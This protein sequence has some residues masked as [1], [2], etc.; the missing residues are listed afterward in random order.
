MPL[1]SHAAEANVMLATP[2]L[3]REGAIRE[4]DMALVFVSGMVVI[5]AISEM[6]ISGTGTTSVPAITTR[7][8]RSQAALPDSPITRSVSLVR[9]ASIGVTWPCSSPRCR[10]FANK[11]DCQR[12]RIFT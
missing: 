10:C 8:R 9:I 11:R 4:R 12:R 2:H 7:L 6:M 5:L 3:Y 1:R